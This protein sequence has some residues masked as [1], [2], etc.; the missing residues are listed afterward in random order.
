VKRLVSDDYDAFVEYLKA[1]ARPGDAFHVWDYAD[2]CLDSNTLT[3][4]KYPD[5]EGRVPARG[6]Y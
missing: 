6:S 2:L 4:G 1:G 5:A 3:D